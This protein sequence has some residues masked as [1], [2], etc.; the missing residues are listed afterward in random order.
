[1]PLSL[2]EVKAEKEQL[3]H[4]PAFP[5]DVSVGFTWTK[6]GDWALAIRINTLTV[7]KADEV[8]AQV[9]QLLS[10]KYRSPFE[11]GIGPIELQ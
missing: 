1:M 3:K 6:D 5:K 7:E 11:I 8:A 2:S 4:D 10:T 9:R